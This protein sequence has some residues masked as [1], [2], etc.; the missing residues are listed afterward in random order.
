MNQASSQGGHQGTPRNEQPKVEGKVTDPVCGM[1]IDPAR[2][3][4]KREFEGQTFHFC[5]TGCASKFDAAPGTYAK[6]P[7]ES[8]KGK[9][10]CS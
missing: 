3:A 4:T 5:A 7:G 9:G 10:C 2:S 6:R 8:P 1:Q